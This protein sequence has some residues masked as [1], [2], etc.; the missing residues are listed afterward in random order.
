MLFKGLEGGVFE[1]DEGRSQ[2]IG[3]PERPYPSE[4]HT[5]THTHLMGIWVAAASFYQRIL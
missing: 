4:T 3:M 2:G 5:H 1:V